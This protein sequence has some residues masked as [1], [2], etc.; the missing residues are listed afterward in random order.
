MRSKK[1]CP[2]NP[3][4]KP[5]GEFSI[6]WCKIAEEMNIYLNKKLRSLYDVKIYNYIYIYI[7]CLDPGLKST[8]CSTLATPPSQKFHRSPTPPSNHSPKLHIFQAPW[9]T[10][11][12]PVPLQ[13]F[14]LGRFQPAQFRKNQRPDPTKKWRFGSD[15]FPFW[16][17]GFSASM[18][19]FFQGFFLLSLRIQAWPRKGIFPTILFWWDWDHQSSSRE[20]SGFLGFCE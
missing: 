2:N 15:D 7:V 18:L 14:S 20:R 13:D 10:Y 19:I 12:S 8:R 16:I 5:A 17:R 4:K 1:V 3:S 6:C 11:D 9:A